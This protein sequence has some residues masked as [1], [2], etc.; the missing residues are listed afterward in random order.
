MHIPGTEE[1]GRYSEIPDF[2]GMNTMSC[3]TEEVMFQFICV[4]SQKD[5]SK[6]V[7]NLDTSKLEHFM[8]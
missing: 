8:I 5:I 4:S 7:I 3:N 1:V 6:F 2:L